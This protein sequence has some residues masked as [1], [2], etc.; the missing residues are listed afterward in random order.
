MAAVMVF[1]VYLRSVVTW[2][3]ISVCQG[4]LKFREVQMLTRIAAL[5]YCTGT[6]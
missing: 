5:G 3:L 6:M 1:V 2:S 4:S